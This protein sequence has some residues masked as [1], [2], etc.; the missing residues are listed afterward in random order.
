MEPMA[1]NQDNTP[2]K[3]SGK[4]TDSKRVRSTDQNEYVTFKHNAFD[5]PMLSIA[6]YQHRNEIIPM[7]AVV[8]SNIQ[9]G[10]YENIDAIPII[11]SIKPPPNIGDTISI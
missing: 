1:I 9:H 11:A 4:N 6:V 5:A 3:Y 2:E 7:R 10:G 8:A